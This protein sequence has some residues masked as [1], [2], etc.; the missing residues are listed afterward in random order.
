MAEIALVASIAAI[1]Q[2][3]DRIIGIT[4]HYIEAVHD[5]PRDLHII[6]I[7][8]S[9]LKAIFESLMLLQESHESHDASYSMLQKLGEKDGVV[10]GCRHSVSELVKLLDHEVQPSSGGK[11]R[12]L[13]ATLSNLAWPL[14]ETK[15]NKLLSDISRYKSTITILLSTEQAYVVYYI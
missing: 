6:R 4:K 14:K 3:S 7:E 9:T 13:H 2:I 10:E 5:A 8:I 12:R 11:R 15:V 1:I